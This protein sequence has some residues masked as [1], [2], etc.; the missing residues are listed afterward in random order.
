MGLLLKG[1]PNQIVDLEFLATPPTSPIYV[2]GTCDKDGVVF[3]WFMC[4]ARDDLGIDVELKLLKKYSFF[5]LRKSTTAFYSRIRLAGTVE[6]GTMLLVPNDGSNCRVVTFHCEPSQPDHALHPAITGPEVPKQILAAEPSDIIP[7]HPLTNTPSKPTDP[8]H[9]ETFIPIPP[10]DPY[11]AHQETENFVEA[12][13]KE[14]TETVLPMPDLQ[15]DPVMSE[16]ISQPH[17]EFVDALDHAVDQP[18][19]PTSVDVDDFEDSTHLHTIPASAPGDEYGASITQE[20]QEHSAQLQRD[21]L[22]LDPSLTENHPV[23]DAQPLYDQPLY[24]QP[25]PDTHA[26]A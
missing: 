18:E 14:Y 16:T 19:Q 11:S 20:E 17:D 2:L 12:E 13:G 3:L 4:I 24:D 10:V 26:H 8:D 23:A 7:E 15:P 6:S 5:S 21:Q 1:H 22:P 9:L 25:L